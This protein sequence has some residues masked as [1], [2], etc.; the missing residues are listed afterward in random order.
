MFVLRCSHSDKNN[1]RFLDCFIQVRCEVKTLILRIAADQLLQ[2]WFTDGDL[3]FLQKGDLIPIDVHSN[4][5][6]PG[7]GKTGTGY[8][9]H[10]TRSDYTDA[11]GQLLGPKGHPL[12][13]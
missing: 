12:F 5:I 13:I 2:S 11:H 10:I 8:Q 9:T 7:L 4:H 3:T 1:E 6:I